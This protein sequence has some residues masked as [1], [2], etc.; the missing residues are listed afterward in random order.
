MSERRYLTAEQVAEKMCCSRQHVYNMLESGQLPCVD[1]SM[2]GS[3]KKLR[4]ISEDA[5]D[6]WLSARTQDRRRR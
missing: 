3:K 6:K 4:R 1:F 2:P 5:L